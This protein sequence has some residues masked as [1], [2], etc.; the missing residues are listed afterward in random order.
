MQLLAAVGSLLMAALAAACPAAGY[1]LGPRGVAGA[2]SVGHPRR[3]S[4]FDVAEQS[5][6]PAGAHG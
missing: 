4:P 1:A 2:H 6:W 3:P 5:L